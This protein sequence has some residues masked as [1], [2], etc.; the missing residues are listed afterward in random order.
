MSAARSALPN[1]GIAANKASAG[2]IGQ[3]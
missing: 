3:R 1:A 2:T